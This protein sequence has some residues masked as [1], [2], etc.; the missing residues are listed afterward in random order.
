MWLFVGGMDASE[1]EFPLRC[2]HSAPHTHIS[3]G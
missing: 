1:E 2:G 3:H